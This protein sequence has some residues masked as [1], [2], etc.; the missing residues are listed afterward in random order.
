MLEGGK[1]M[2]D[3]DFLRGRKVE[4]GVVLGEEPVNK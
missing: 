2:K 3:S 4:E 1:R